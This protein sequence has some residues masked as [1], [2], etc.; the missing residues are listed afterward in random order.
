MVADLVTVPCPLCEGEGAR[1]Y[2][3]GPGRFSHSSET[4]EPEEAVETCSYCGGAGELEVCASCSEPLEIAEGRER[5][6]CEPMQ[7]PRAA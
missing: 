2:L 1:L 3:G 5:C 7:M 4:F 6:G